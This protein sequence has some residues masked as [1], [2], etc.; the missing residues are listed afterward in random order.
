[1]ISCTSIDN[2][3]FSIEKCLMRSYGCDAASRDISPLLWYI[4]TGRASLPFLRALLA[5]KPYMVAR[6]LHKGGSDMEVINR[7]KS[8]LL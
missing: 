3:L 5:S 4:N 2:M 6:R 8:I 1:M 7:I